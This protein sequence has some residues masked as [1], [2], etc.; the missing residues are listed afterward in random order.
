MMKK[1][2]SPKS[3]IAFILFFGFFNVLDAESETPKNSFVIQSTCGN[4]E[5][6]P[7]PSMA[8]YDDDIDVDINISDNSC[9]MS[10]L[11]FDFFYDTSMF[12]YLGVSTQSCLTSD[13]S[14]LDAY[15]F[16][17]GQVRI[18]GYA[19]NGSYIQ[20]TD[21]G[22]LVT[23]T[24]KV[25]CQCGNCSDGQ[26]STITIDDYNDDLAPYVTQPARGVFTLICCSGA[27]A[28]PATEA[29][30]WGDV[31]YIPVSYRQQLESNI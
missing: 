12:A 31:E 5:V 2:I 24:L 6:L 29:G 13:W 30:T 18:G 21:N 1:L 28:L 19:G 17:P 14:I 27:I 26:Q 20:P 15:E 22:T 23:V 16:S 8:T 11:G 9:E 25:I 3:I 4:V 7:T 10:A